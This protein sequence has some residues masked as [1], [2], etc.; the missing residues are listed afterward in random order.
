LAQKAE[1]MSP[2]ALLHVYDLA[3]LQSAARV[4][5]SRQ[6][7]RS[8]SARAL[9]A[10]FNALVVKAVRPEV[11]IELGAREATFSR[12]V[13]LALPDA[14]VHALEANPYT[15]ERYR[16]IAA[17]AGVE[18]HNL[19]AG[20]HVG[21][22]TFNVTLK[23]RGIEVPKTRGGNSLLTVLGGED[24]ELEKV[25]VHMVTADQFAEEHGLL[26]RPAALWIDVEGLAFEVLSGASR[27]LEH[28]S[29]LMVEVEDRQVWSGQKTSLAVKLLLLEAGFIPVARDFEYKAQYNMIFVRPEVFHLNDVRQYLERSLSE[30]HVG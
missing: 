9:A 1:I 21:Q 24:I 12:H 2:D 5:L 19:A 22:V 3:L 7:S 6:E 27:L 30:S 10:L 18:Y 11:V 15:Y 23:E 4:D 17:E 14:E 25:D 20:D 16:P 13:K 26:G 29:L 8:A 28:T